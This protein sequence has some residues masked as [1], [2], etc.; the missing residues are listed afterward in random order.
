L[1]TAPVVIDELAR[2]SQIDGATRRMSSVAPGASSM[3]PSP[4]S[5]PPPVGVRRASA[6]PPSTHRVSERPASYPSGAGGEAGSDARERGGGNVGA[7][8]AAVSIV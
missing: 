7:A 8:P 4:T 6:F 1:D 5:P 2:A 3:S